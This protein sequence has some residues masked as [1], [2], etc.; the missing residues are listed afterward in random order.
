MITLTTI[1]T[2]TALF[3]SAGAMFEGA[4]KVISAF[5]GAKPALGA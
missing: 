1:T 4:A 3:V 2:I 5:R